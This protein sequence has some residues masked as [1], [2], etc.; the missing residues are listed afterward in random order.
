L[1][2]DGQAPPAVGAP[3]LAHGELE[4]SAIGQAW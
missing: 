2:L 4:V 3:G 1:L